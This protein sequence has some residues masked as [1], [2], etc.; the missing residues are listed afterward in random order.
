MSDTDFDFGFTAVDEEEL[1]T[2]AAPVLPQTPVVSPDALN[3][4]TAKLVDLEG[5]IA[6]IRPASSAH[7]ARVEEKI[8][9][10]LNME[11]SELT[12]SVQEQGQNISAVLDEV[13]ERTNAMRP[14]I[15]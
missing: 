1:Q 11:L 6:A 4:V 12:A 5:K 14:W 2:T 9:K 13:E 10:M 8:D 7:L 15:S 3:S